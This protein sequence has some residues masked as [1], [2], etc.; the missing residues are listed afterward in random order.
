MQHLCCRLRA[1]K[2]HILWQGSQHK[3]AASLIQYLI[4]RIYLIFLFLSNHTYFLFL[5]ILPSL[6]IFPSS[7]AWEL[8]H[9]QDILGNSSAFVTELE[10]FNSI[11]CPKEREV[12]IQA[13]LSPPRGWCALSVTQSWSNSANRLPHVSHEGRPWH[14]H[15]PDP[16]LKVN[17]QQS[18]Q[19]WRQRESTALLLHVQFTQHSR[20]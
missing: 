13:V 3:C 8:Y 10:E 14:S 18:K 16:A 12:R 19:L 20:A 11:Y 7:R 17:H 15:S 9:D 2:T 4:T 6:S 1:R 5:A